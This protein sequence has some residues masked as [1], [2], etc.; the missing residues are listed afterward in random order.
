MTSM[1][2]LNT[3]AILLLTAPLIVGRNSTSAELLTPG[4]YKLLAS[5]LYKQLSKEPADLLSEDSKGILRDLPPK[6]DGERLQRLLDRG[7]ALGQAIDRWQAR[8]IWVV[9]RA[10]QNY[11]QRLKDRLKDDRP[12]ILYGCGDLRILDKG[13][14]AVVG[15]RDVDSSLIEYTQG[16]GNLV[17]KAGRTLVSGGARGVDLAAMRG[18]LEAGGTVAGVM[19]DSLERAVINRE[20]RHVLMEGRLVLV[21]PYDP[22]LGF[23]NWQ[24]MQRNKLIYA[25]SDAALVVSSD[26]NK[27]GTWTGAVEQLDKLNFVP[28][29][30]RSTGQ[31]SSG[32]EALR[33]KGAKPWPN[34]QTVTEFEQIFLIESSTSSV[35][36]QAGLSFFDTDQQSPLS[37]VE[38][39]NKNL[40][41]VTDLQVH[42]DL[43]DARNL[44][45]LQPE[46]AVPLA[47]A[48]ALSN[49]TDVL[50]INSTVTIQAISPA[51]ALFNSVKELIGHLLVV[52]MKDTEVAEALNVSCVQAKAWLR[53]L[54][55]D[56]FVKKQKK[57]LGYVL[58]REELF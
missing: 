36:K 29:Y 57:P 33:A 47:I 55:E 7:F 20:N 39:D 50:P 15:S 53:R 14:L 31:T 12:A 16:I 43:S 3:Q 42:N 5:H 10:D 18:A 13:G 40:K 11:P 35:P 6:L 27:G 28:I 46:T 49:S 17:A 48:E 23:Q 37:E 26:V 21:S 30:L 4:E 24:A 54:E 56:G 32:L 45:K 38:L 58:R 52:P 2:S 25:F 19:A 41:P 1:L 8:S 9:S 44:L 22:G 51:D 34:P